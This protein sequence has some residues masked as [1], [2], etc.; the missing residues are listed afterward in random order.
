MAYRVVLVRERPLVNVSHRRSAGRIL[1]L[2]ACL[3]V[4][5]VA[6][7]W[8]DV[9]VSSNQGP[10]GDFDP[11][12]P[13]TLTL[14]ANEHASYRIEYHPGA[15]EYVAT[16]LAGNFT[17]VQGFP[18]DGPIDDACTGYAT[19]VLTCPEAVPGGTPYRILLFST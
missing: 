14:F 11:N 19:K 1:A 8:A 3:F 10:P 9:Q 2:S 6:P 4:C 17:R 18:V 7:S 5:L 16:S 12:D 15:H 13:G